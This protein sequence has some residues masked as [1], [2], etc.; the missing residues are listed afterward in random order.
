MF[1]R[2]WFNRRNRRNKP[3]TATRN[4][5]NKPRVFGIVVNRRAQPLQDYVQA[6]VKIDVSS[7]W[8][9]PLAQFFAAD[10]LS[11]SLQEKEKKAKRLFLDFDSYAVTAEYP[12]NRVRLEQSKTEDSAR[13][14]RAL[15]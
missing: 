8:P 15:H 3:V 10:D 14:G 7:F 12:V 4:G 13:R 9:K 1:F 5:F 6:A 2:T 11:W